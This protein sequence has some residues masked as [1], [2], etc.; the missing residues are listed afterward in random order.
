MTDKFSATVTMNGSQSKIWKTL[1]DP[2]LM[3]MWMGD[4]ELELKVQTSWEVGSPFSVHGFHHVR[5]ENKGIVLH[6]QPEQ[7]L[8][9]SHLSSFS[10]LPDRQENY[11]VL[12]FI[13]TPIG[14]QVQ[15]TIDIFNFPTETI[16]RHL[17]FYWRATL[18]KIKETVETK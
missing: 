7:K 3:I 4:K 15:L 16:R 18:A 17:E 8:S 11:S 5:F 9:Y 6:F 14:P 10:R 12:E 2:E 1:T 13:L